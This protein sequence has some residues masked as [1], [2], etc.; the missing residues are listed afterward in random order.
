MGII[1]FF[2][3]DDTVS[4][5]DKFSNAVI[6]PVSNTYYTV[7]IGHNIVVNDGWAA[8]IVVKGKTRDVLPAGAHQLSLINLPNTTQVLNLH[9]GKLKKQGSSVTVELPQKF[10]CDLYYVNLGQVLDFPWHT[11]RVPVKSKLYGKYKVG[12]NGILSF[13]VVDVAKFLSLMLLEHGHLFS[14]Q[15]E[16]V[17][18]RFINEEMYDSILFSDF[19]N[20]RQFADKQTINQFLLNK[21]NENFN[22]Y[23]LI[24]DNVDTQNVKFF[25]KVNEQ[26]S[27]E[28]EQMPFSFSTTI[29]TNA[30]LGDGTLNL[31]QPINKQQ[32]KPIFN[33]NQVAQ[34][35]DNQPFF[36]EEDEGYEREVKQKVKV[37]KKY[38]NIQ[39]VQDEIN[40]TLGTDTSRVDI[41]EDGPTKIKLNNKQDGSN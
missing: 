32:D 9:K 37:R 17:L 20:P 15:G 36:E 28:S 18:S 23:G 12:I 8:A 41:M 31:N 30:V 22:H 21:L 7:N 19:Y 13:H 38:E 2:K 35:A 40:K 1:D 33:S 6:H 25:G 16:R 14:G 3:R 29:D 39:Q 26:I 27:K 5:P 11:G 4:L 34:N 24:I 10:K